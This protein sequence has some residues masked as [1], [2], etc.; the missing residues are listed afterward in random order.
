MKAIFTISIHK[1]NILNSLLSFCAFY[2]MVLKEQEEEEEEE[3]EKERF[4]FASISDSS[5]A[6]LY[7]IDE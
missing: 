4:T 5:K 7:D 6:L 2:A 1:E 3:R